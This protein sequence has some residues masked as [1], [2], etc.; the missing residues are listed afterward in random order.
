MVRERTWP[1][2]NPYLA[3]GQPLLANPQFEVLYP[4]TWLLPLLAPWTYY[5]AFVVFHSLFSAAGVYLLCRTLGLGAAPAFA[6]AGL[7]V[8]SGPW[9][10]LVSNWLHLAGAA[11]MPWVLLAT[12]R[13]LRARSTRSAMWLGAAGGLQLLAGSADMALLAWLASGLRLLGPIVSDARRAAA[14]APGAFRARRPDRARPRRRSVDP[15]RRR[16]R[17]HRAGFDFRGGPDV[18]VRAPAVPAADAGAGAFQG[19]EPRPD[20]GRAP[21]RIARAV[22]VLA[23]P[24]LARGR[25]RGRRRRR[26]PRAVATVRARVPGPGSA[27]RPGPVHARLSLLH[28]RVPAPPARALSDEDDAAGR[29]VLGGAGR[30]RARGLPPRRPGGARR[31]R[32]GQ[33]GGWGR[34]GAGGGVPF[35][36]AVA[37]GLGA[38]PGGGHDRGRARPGDAPPRRHRG[39]RFRPRRPRR[40]GAAPAAPARGRARRR[41][42]RG[43]PR[44]HA[45]RSQRHRPPRGVLGPARLAAASRRPALL[46]RLRGG[47]PEREPDPRG[48]ARAPPWHRRL[49]CREPAALGGGRR[50]PHVSVPDAARVVGHRGKL[51]HR[52]ADLLPRAPRVS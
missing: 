47:L 28:G 40:G 14:P 2:W 3:F 1:L 46:A 30:G 36:T 37:R 4:F 52:P 45:R 41:V 44:G 8:S 5:D 10:S 16:R 42:R 29:A 48:R 31:H 39:A 38:P 22:P 23:L 49:R 24:R 7:W 11:W 17:R 20:R 43:R 12:E 33:P 18:L 6:G 51:R 21:V 25:P 19:D 13:L 50:L 34:P 9:L 15:H 32:R 35:R 27:G 26:P